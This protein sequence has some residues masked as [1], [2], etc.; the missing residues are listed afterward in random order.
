MG[1]VLYAMVGIAEQKKRVRR[2][3]RRRA[4]PI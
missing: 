2:E 4:R 1:C 3:L